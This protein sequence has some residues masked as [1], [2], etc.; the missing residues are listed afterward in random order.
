MPA[1]IQIFILKLL[2]C[3]PEEEIIN[4][5]ADASTQVASLWVPNTTFNEEGN[6]EIKF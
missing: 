2:C 4:I 1:N 6:S 3:I 5:K